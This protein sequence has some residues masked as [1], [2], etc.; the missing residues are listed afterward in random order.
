MSL[1]TFEGPEGWVLTPEGAAIHLE[2]RTAVVADIHLGYEWAR[3]NGGDCIPSHSL[4]ETRTKLEKVFRR[5]KVERLVVAGDLVESRRFCRRTALDL[6]RLSEWLVESRIDFVSL[7]G[8]HDPP[9]RPP[10]ALTM[11]IDGWTIAHGHRPVGT[12]RKVTGHLHPVLRAG[13]ISA[14]CFL[15][16]T[17]TIVLPA[18]SPNAAGVGLNGLPTA[19]LAGE[20]H[21]IASSGEELLDFGLASTLVQMNELARY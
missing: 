10:L 11:E 1:G 7:A 15:I 6:A 9:R 13:G 18:F 4:D 3:G 20:L 12:T 8:N 2:S 14:P 16:G 17:E 19:F 21:C 5:A